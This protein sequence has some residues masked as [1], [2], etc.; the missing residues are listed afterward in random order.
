MKVGRRTAA[1]LAGIFAGCALF[2]AGCA[3]SLQGIKVRAQG[4]P[5]ED[6]FRSLSLA[7]TVDGYPVE[8]VDPATFTLESGW[9]TL[10]KAECGA[11]TATVDAL[12]EGRITLKMV[13]R[14]GLYDVMLTPWMR[15]RAMG[16]ESITVV[17]PTHPLRIKWEKAIARLIEREARDED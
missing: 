4:P 11:D 9:R 14:G 13:R 12:P 17:S 7:V 5:I 3:P 16:T 6:A 10:K 2:S 8:R 1:V 15:T